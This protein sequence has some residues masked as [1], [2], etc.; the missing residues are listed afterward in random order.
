MNKL[1]RIVEKA[2][3]NVE[4]EMG[5]MDPSKAEKVARGARINLNHEEFRVEV[6]DA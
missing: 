6:I 3:G 1:V 2:T 5:P 4:T